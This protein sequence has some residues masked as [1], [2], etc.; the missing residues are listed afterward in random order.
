MLL[1]FHAL[2]VAVKQYGATHDSAAI[3]NRS[4][5]GRGDRNG[6]KARLARKGQ[7]LR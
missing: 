1:Q 6:R 5:S 2:R 3:K 4:I 7:E